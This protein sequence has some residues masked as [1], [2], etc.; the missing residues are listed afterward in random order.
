VGVR[1]RTTWQKGKCPN[2]GGRPKKDRTI[3]ELAKEHTPAAIAAL[4]AALKNPRERVPAA[5]ELLNR[6]W[7]KP[8]QPIAGDKGL[9]LVVDFQWADATIVSTAVQPDSMVPLIDATPTAVTWSAD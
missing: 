7:G 1:T 6:A 4:V 3:E 8:K 9:P 2:P 5:T